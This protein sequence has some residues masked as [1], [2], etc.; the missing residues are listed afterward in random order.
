[1][2]IEWK[3]D[4]VILNHHSNVMMPKVYHSA[5]LPENASSLAVLLCY[6]DV[7]APQAHQRNAG[8]QCTEATV[9]YRLS[10]LCRY[11][12]QH[13]SIT[14]SYGAVL[15]PEHIFH[16]TQFDVL[17]YSAWFCDMCRCM[18]GNDKGLAVCNFEHECL[19]C[20]LN[21]DFK[22]MLKICQF[23]RFTY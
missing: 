11:I 3:G 18:N 15:V 16:S 1:M 23:R 10:S 2:E 5:R 8:D 22:V 6:M 12:T 7:T 14:G 9:V 17:L 4:V 20:F 13:L 19:S 21:A